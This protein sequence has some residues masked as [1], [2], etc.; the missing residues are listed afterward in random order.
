M[1]KI[2][3]KNNILYYFLISNLRPKKIILELI[4]TNNRE[5]YVE[6]QEILGIFLNKKDLDI[7]RIKIE[8]RKNSFHIFISNEELI[9]LSYTN[10]QLTSDQN[11]QLF[12]EINAYLLNN[13]KERINDGQSFLMEDEKEDIKEIINKYIGDVLS[14]KTIDSYLGSRDTENEKEI[15]KV[16]GNFDT[17]KEKKSENKTIEEILD[18][19]NNENNIVIKNKIKN[20]SKTSLNEL[21]EKSLIEKE[22]RNE[23]FGEEIIKNK[24]NKN[25]TSSHIKSD[26]TTSMLLKNDFKNLKIKNSAK[27]VFRNHS[28]I[29]NTILEGEKNS[30]IKEKPK[31]NIRN[32]S[33]NKNLNKNYSYNKYN[34]DNLNLKKY[35]PDSCSKKVIIGI[36]I[37]VIVLQI[38][39]IPL[40]INFYDFSL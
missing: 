22:K 16:E 35:K 27:T 12:D 40:V 2:N 4:N 33:S 23:S 34:Y 26:N 24:I 21:N 38:A 19:K 7:E 30:E 31:I 1:S 9:F 29:K 25:Q 17:I 8:S 18:N 5:I 36:L 32:P 11:F 14:I 3:F 15:L 20:F 10:K 28:D 13:L 39:T 6:A 37:S